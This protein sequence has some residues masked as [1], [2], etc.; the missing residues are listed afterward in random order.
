MNYDD[1]DVDTLGL[2]PL[3]RVRPAWDPPRQ[4]NRPTE[5]IEVIDLDNNRDQIKPTTW[6]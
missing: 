5:D 2:N 3:V 6:H 4:D 1:Y